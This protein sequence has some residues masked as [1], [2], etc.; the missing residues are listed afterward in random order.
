MSLKPFICA[1]AIALVGLSAAAQELTVDQIIAKNIAAHGGL[2]KI[3]AQKSLRASGHMTLG[4]GLEAPITYEQKRPGNFRFEL[5]LQGLTLVQAYDGRTG[6]LV[7]PFE[8]KKDPELMGEDDLKDAQEQA[9]IEGPLVNYK[10]KGNKVELVGREK[11]EGSDAYK[12]KVT[13]KNGDVRYI[14]LDADTFLEVKE[15]SKRT[16]RG[17]EVEA[18]T[19]FGDYKE[20]GGVMMAHSF[21]QGPKG[22]PQRQH[23]TIEKVEINPTID[24]ARF[25]MPKAAAADNKPATKPESGETKP[26]DKKPEDKPA[27]KPPVKR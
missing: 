5:T 24:D 27:T 1:L 8:G 13:L 11:V 22:S 7:N 9:D 20:E 18:E 25:V 26:A 16:I 12:L 21:D 2:D 23:L 10:E 17:S 15:E 4:Q 14:Y 3:M 19:I 6:W